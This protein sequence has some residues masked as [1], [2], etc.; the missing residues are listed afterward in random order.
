MRKRR[1]RHQ[2][3]VLNAHAVVGFVTFLQTAQNGD[4]VL[5]ARFADIDRL[6]AAFES[7][8]LFNVFPVLVQRGRADRPEFAPRQLRFEQVGG[9][10]GALRLPGAHDGVKFVDEEDDLALGRS[11]LLEKRLQTLLEFPAILGSGHHRTEI[12]GDDL[13]ALQRFRHVAIDDPAGE[14]FHQGC[15][16]HPGLADEHGVVLSP[17]RE[18]LHDPANLVVPSNDRI[19]LPLPRQSREIPAVLFQGLKLFLRVLISHSLIPAH[20]DQRLEHTVPRD[21]VGRENPLQTRPTLLDQTK[22][23][24]LGGREVIL[25]FGR[26]LGGGSEDILEILTRI[27]LGGAIDLGAAAEFRLEILGEA[28]QR[29]AQLLKQL[30]NEA[31]VLTNQGQGQVLAVQL[32]VIQL[33]RDLLRGVHRFLGLDGEFFEVHL[34]YPNA[35]RVPGSL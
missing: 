5:D 27:D 6:K 21:R 10:G 25:E 29:H 19:N 14:S 35:V 13:L 7:G 15:L 20:L 1:R 32:L 3:A 31:F 16:A 9:I 26:F 8:I 2:G 17:A 18:H 28:G 30:R 4:G 22:Q 24:V 11:D 33:L 12:H 34:S 23:Q